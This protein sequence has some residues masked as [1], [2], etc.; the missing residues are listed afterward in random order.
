M[1]SSFD[2]IVFDPSKCSKLTME[3]KRE[4]VYELSQLSHGAPEMLQ[5]WSR[6]EILQ[7]LCAEMG[8]ERKYTGLTKSKI[9]ENLLKIVSEKKSLEHRAA[10]DLEIQLSPAS[11]KAAKRQRKTD[12]PSRLPV[13]VNNLSISSGIGDLANA[14]Y[15]KNS[16]CKAN[17]MR[18]DAFCKRCSCCI[19][20][21]YDDNK[22]PSL[23]L[24][25]SSEPPFQ[26]DSCGMSCHLECALQHER[27]GI[28]KNG[29]HSGLDGGFYCVSCGKV[30]DLLG[31]WKKQLVVAKDTRR[32]DILCYRVSLSQKLLNG[33]KKYQKLYD[34]VDEAVNKLELEVGPLSGLPLKMGRGIV[35]RLSSGPEV[36]KLCALAVGS[37]DVM[38]SSA[39]PYAF[40]NPMT[41]GTILLAPSTIR[42]DGV[43][44]TSVTVVL[45]SED[46]S[47]EDIVVYNLWHRKAREMDYPAGQTCTLR[48]PN[49]R[50]VV[51]GLSPATEYIFKVISFNGKRE[52]GMCEA[53]CSTIGAGGE[54]QKSSIVERSQSPATNCSSMSN[55]SSV[56]DETNNVTPYNDRNE[57]R[58]DNYFNYCENADKIVSANISND[59][60]KYTNVDQEGAQADSVS[61][62]CEERGAGMV[63]S[64]PSS[65]VLKF[66]KLQSQ[67]VQVVEETSID[68]RS[69]SPAFTGLECVPYVASS[70]AGLPVTPCKLDIFKDGVGRN[71]RPKPS[72]TGK[73][74]DMGGEPQAGSSSKKRGG[75]RQDEH[76][77]NDNS[78]RDFEY[79]VKIIRWLECEGHIEKNFRQKFLTWYSLRATPQEVRI[80]KVFVDTFI[81]DPASLAGQLFDTFSDS[82][83]SKR[84]SAVPAGFCMKLWH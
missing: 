35:N 41:Q 37:L 59:T 15:C 5:S 1:D 26:G 62:L 38:L 16:A 4:L 30:N 77:R 10:A 58:E 21:R 2:G 57:T 32:V 42:F 60:I 83:S 27:S 76:A 61:V 81:D 14:V 31:C 7:I 47:S 6:Q 39:V 29:Q 68:N 28:S 84:L 69:S 25:C 24:I 12:H 65:G 48:S 82:I 80:V 75:E 19:C 66:E 78:D 23:W 18:E 56:E 22:D 64:A 40:P 44:A 73:D 74:V 46:P 55:P 43:S 20:Y 53:R 72:G 63:V 36:Q 71:G 3:E 79:C 17:L 54:V 67:E 13:A 9:I 49:A 50:F 33:T 51:S 34:I 8:K 70:E 45:G 11:Q 52:S